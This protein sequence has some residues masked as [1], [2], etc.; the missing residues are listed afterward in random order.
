M[1]STALNILFL[2]TAHN[3]LSQRLALVL[4]DKGHH[5]TVELA[6]S[7][8][9]MIEATELAKVDHPAGPIVGPDS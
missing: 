2:C 5:V 4:Q 7:D 9:I 3:S 8:A 1:S 6:I